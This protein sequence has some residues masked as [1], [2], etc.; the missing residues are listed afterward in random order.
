MHW[1]KHFI[2]FGSKIIFKYLGTIFV[3]KFNLVILQELLELMYSS[4]QKA[5][6]VQIMKNIV[7]ILGMSSAR[8]NYSSTSTAH[9][10]YVVLDCSLS[11]GCCMPIMS[12]CSPCQHVVL[13]LICA[14]AINWNVASVSFPSHTILLSL[15]VSLG[16]FWEILI[17]LQSSLHI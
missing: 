1:E 5:H 9:W 15:S 10:P 8:I 4:T 14:Y 3:W 12:K 2:S 6:F 13:A 17:K 16:V 7:L 11:N